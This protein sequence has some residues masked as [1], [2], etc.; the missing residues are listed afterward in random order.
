VST[1]WGLIAGYQ[2]Q[3]DHDTLRHDPVFQLIC[4]RVPDDDAFS[5]TA[6]QPM[7]SRFESA[8]EIPSLKRLRELLV[9]QFLDAFGT[10]PTR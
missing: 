4:D 1:F 8:V 6:S 3:N 10:P 2:D 9:D 7:L 5:P